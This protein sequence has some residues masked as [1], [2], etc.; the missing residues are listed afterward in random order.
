LAVRTGAK[1]VA[2]VCGSGNRVVQVVQETGFLSFP[3]RPGRRPIENLPYRPGVH[4]AEV[5]KVRQQPGILGGTAPLSMALNVLA[6]LA[7]ATDRT[8]TVL[9]GVAGVML[10]AL[11]LAL[12]YTGSCFALAQQPASPKKN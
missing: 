4:R 8:G 5:E 12:S 10:P 9:A 2:E 7:G 11:I 1:V 6:F 3:F